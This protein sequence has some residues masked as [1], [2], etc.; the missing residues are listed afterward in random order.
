[1]VLHVCGSSGGFPDASCRPAGGDRSTVLHLF[2]HEHPTLNGTIQLK[3][4]RNQWVNV[5]SRNLRNKCTCTHLCAGRK[6]SWCVTEWLVVLAQWQE[7][8]SA[9]IKVNITMS[10]NHALQYIDILPNVCIEVFQKDRD[11]L[12]LN[13]WQ[14]ITNFFHEF[15]VQCTWTPSPS[16]I[17]S[18]THLPAEDLQVYPLQP[19][20]TVLALHC[21]RR[22][23]TY[24]LA[25]QY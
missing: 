8:S 23:F 10:A 12:G 17:P 15:Q 13:P 24:R 16:G 9:V 5:E 22:V 21:S 4:C 3:L 19:D 6:C 20:Q 7:G 25:Q 14:I 2:W 11:F 1:M 18:S